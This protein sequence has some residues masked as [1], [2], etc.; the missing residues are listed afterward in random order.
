[1]V[2]CLR[3]W[4]R[5]MWEAAVLKI[6]ID[7]LTKIKPFFFV[8]L[9][10]PVLFN[11]PEMM[12]ATV[13]I[14]CVWILVLNIPKLNNKN[15]LSRDISSNKINYYPCIPI[16]WNGLLVLN[17]KLTSKAKFYRDLSLNLTSA[18]LEMVLAKQPRFW[19]AMGIF[20]LIKIILA[21]LF[22]RK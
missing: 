16:V 15:K 20:I 18:S 17:N 2:H 6:L 4:P 1:M 8:L 12:T 5:R 21:N 22:T 14:W 10:H 9:K 19:V 13:K 11:D 7:C 3:N